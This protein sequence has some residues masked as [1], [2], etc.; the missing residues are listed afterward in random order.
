MAN[1]KPKFRWTKETAPRKGG[2]PGRVTRK[3]LLR[4]NAEL[5]ASGKGVDP[6]VVLMG[7]AGDESVDLDMRLVASRDVMPYVHT[8]KPQVIEGSL[9]LMSTFADAVKG[10][11]KK[12]P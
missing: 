4:T 12:K 9:A 3:T 1:P 8:K 11:K 5:I 2:K 6:K 10:R 7:I